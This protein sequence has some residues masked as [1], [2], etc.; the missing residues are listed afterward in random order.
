[1]SER[2]EV[3]DSVKHTSPP[4]LRLPF[5]KRKVDA[6]EWV[7]DH[8]AGLCVTLIVY[9]VLCIGFVAG[10]IAVGARPAVSGIV[11]DVQ[12]PAEIEAER[13]RRELEARRDREDASPESWRDVRNRASNENLEE[14]ADG[15]TAMSASLRESAEAV[16]ERMQANREAYEQGL[17]EERAIRERMG[18]E[19]SGREV[20]DARVSGRVTVSYSLVDPVRTRRHIEIPAY[21]CE[22]GGEVVIGITVDQ[23][24]EVVGAKVL[25]G[26]DHCMREAALEAARR[27][28]FNID[29]QAPARQSG[30][31]TYLFIPQ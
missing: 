22:G 10:K 7:Y 28:S 30:T 13:L 8:R 27:S 24:G 3:S 23:G 11:L 5:E 25:S 18:G 31:I 12:T 4:R 9:L 26:G 20:R 2:T 15:R 17:A 29:P 6:G 1:M 19:D 14:L 21:R 16:G